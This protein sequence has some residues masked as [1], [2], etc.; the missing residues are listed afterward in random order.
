MMSEIEWDRRES[1]AEREQI[2]LERLEQE[3]YDLTLLE[4]G[5]RFPALED[6]ADN[7]RFAVARLMLEEGKP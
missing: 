7:L 1:A 2:A 6:E 5:K 3:A 4:I